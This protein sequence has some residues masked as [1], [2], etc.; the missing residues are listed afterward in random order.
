MS[1]TMKVISNQGELYIGQQEHKRYKNIE[2]FGYGYIDW[3]R[4]IN[5][6]LVTLCDL[7]DSI[8]DGGVSEIEF[9]LENYEEQQKVLRKEEFTTW[10]T[11]FKNLLTTEINKYQEQISATLENYNL[12]I[13]QIRETTNTTIQENYEEISDQIGGIYTQVERTIDEQIQINIRSLIEKINLANRSVEDATQRLS[14]ATS[15]MNSSTQE[16]NNIVVNFKNSFE[17]SFNA[18]RIEVENTLNNYKNV[19]MKYID[20]KIVTVSSATGDLNLRIEKIESDLSKINISTL[21]SYINT[22]IANNINGIIDQNLNQ[23]NQTINLIIK[24]IDDLE[25]E[26]D[27]K[28][29]NAVTSINNGLDNRFS[30]IVANV[31]GISREF[32]ELR[33]SGENSQLETQYFLAETKKYFNSPEDI[34][35]NILDTKTTVLNNTIS[36]NINIKL[37][38]LME[39]IIQQ[40]ETNTKNLKAYIDSEK[41]NFLNALRNTGFDELS[42][43]STRQEEKNLINNRHSD[44]N[45]A[46]LYP[47]SFKLNDIIVLGKEK[48]FLADTSNVNFLVFNLT[49]PNDIFQSFYDGAELR[50]SLNDKALY[51]L[52]RKYFRT[53]IVNVPRVSNILS[54]KD[55][56]FKSNLYTG[57]TTINDYLSFADGNF[58]IENLYSPSGPTI[59]IILDISNEQLSGSTL[60]NL[61][62][63]LTLIGKTKTYN[64]SFIIEDLTNSSKAG[65]AYNVIENKNDFSA[66]IK[67]IVN[68]KT[69]PTFNFIKNTLMD[70]DDVSIPVCEI[71]SQIK[72]GLETKSFRIKVNLP[73][74]ATLNNITYKIDSGTNIIK[75]FGNTTYS[76]NYDTYLANKTANSGNDLYFTDLQTTGVVKIPIASSATTITGTINYKINSISKSYNFAV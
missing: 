25:T 28:L 38:K 59:P 35:M 43:L 21:N 60:N 47:S 72:N 45:V 56:F 33:Q 40:N 8:Q 75:V 52:T 31:D 2:L 6:S 5:Q 29:S 36:E 30:Q 54:I 50:V 14:Q 39:Q 70:N 9:E 13:N 64:L 22:T 65:F 16:V 73:V 66:S 76:A 18:F 62:I 61:P 27:L 68:N 15:A 23:L 63:Y 57:I 3:G 67:S 7:I 41:N 69:I 51:G 17:N 32:A 48:H 44:I 24:D 11:E 49:I 74:G 26:F 34:A 20:D 12:T 71:Q 37:I 19:L 53:L 1:N 58:L 46:N 42:M 55:S 10:K 4:V